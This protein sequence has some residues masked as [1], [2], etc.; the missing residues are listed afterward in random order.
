MEAQGLGGDIGPE[1]LQSDDS[2]GLDTFG[3]IDTLIADLCSYLTLWPHPYTK[4]SVSKA[5]EFLSKGVSEAVL[6]LEGIGGSEN[7]PD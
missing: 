6:T 3:D 1:R 2:Y 4:P 7:G 5:V